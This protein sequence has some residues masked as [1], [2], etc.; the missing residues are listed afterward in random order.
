MQRED[1]DEH[2]ERWL[3]DWHDRHPG[4]TSRAL[5]RGRPSTYD[6]LASFV[7]PGQSVLDLA[8]GD[9]FLLERLHAHG[10]GAITGVDMSP[11]ELASARRRLGDQVTLV[12]ARAQSLPFPDATFDLVT[13]HMALMLMRPVAEVVAEVRRVLRPNGRFAAILSSFRSTDPTDA[14]V[15]VTELLRK[16]QPQGPAIGD[17]C[18]RDAA[19][20]TQL[21]A[22]YSDVHV[23][24]F[25]SD[26]SGTPDEIWALFS[27]IYPFEMI[28]PEEAKAMEEPARAEMR[29]LLRADGTV[30]CA[31][32]YLEVR[33]T[34]EG[35]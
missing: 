17:P 4:A 14:W 18:T 25:T 27:E 12:E 9:G 29:S 30:P 8:C 16:T 1:A 33:A 15:R 11:G 20:L 3:T 6:R 19:G 2:A 31:F 35:A 28:P 5:A 32:A 26:L 24:P 22:A 23:E 10:A 34:K 21:L 7:Q 13:C